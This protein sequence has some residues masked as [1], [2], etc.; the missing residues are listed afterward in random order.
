[1]KGDVEPKGLRYGNEDVFTL[2]GL[3]TALLDLKL[4][5][6]GRQGAGDEAAVR[7]GLKHSVLIGGDTSNVY[8]SARD[9]GSCGIRYCTNERPRF[10]LA[11]HL[12]LPTCDEKTDKD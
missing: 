12:S 4:I 5:G 7:I 10:D 3:E 9:D 1:M 2:V 8:T 6:A 11:K